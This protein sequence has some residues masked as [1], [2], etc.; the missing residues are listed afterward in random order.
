MAKPKFVWDENDIEIVEE[1]TDT[2]E[3]LDA[4]DSEQKEKE[5]IVTTI[6]VNNG[7]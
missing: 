5:K 2:F 4:L 7:N 3:E 1:P 6:E